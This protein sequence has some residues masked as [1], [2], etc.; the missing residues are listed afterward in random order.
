MESQRAQHFQAMQMSYIIQSM[1]TPTQAMSYFL[2]V[3]ADILVRV[4]AKKSKRQ[5]IQA[6]TTTT[7]CT[8]L[9]AVQE[10]CTEWYSTL[11]FSLQTSWPYPWAPRELLPKRYHLHIHKTSDS[12]RR[13]SHLA[14]HTGS[15]S[16]PISLLWEVGDLQ[17]GVL[18][19]SIGYEEPARTVPQWASR[20]LGGGM[21]VPLAWRGTLHRYLEWLSPSILINWWLLSMSMPLN[22]LLCVHS[23]WLNSHWVIFSCHYV[24]RH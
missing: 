18:E 12:T 3:G 22:F 21:Y 10:V 4:K 17:R 23:T 24:R 9:H 11:L 8:V 20:P 1:L 14:V 16:L 15:V 5:L 19:I 2:R 6:N 7:Y 13:L